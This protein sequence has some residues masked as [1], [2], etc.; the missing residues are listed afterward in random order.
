MF[1]LQVEIDLAY[2]GASGIGYDIGRTQM[3]LQHIIE[4]TTASLIAS[5]ENSTFFVGDFAAKVTIYSVLINS[6]IE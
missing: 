1:P 4:C 6:K 2:H 5:V 3:V